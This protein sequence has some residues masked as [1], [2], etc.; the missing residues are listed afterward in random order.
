MTLSGT[1]D[2]PPASG[3]KR[4]QPAAFFSW[5]VFSIAVVVAVGLVSSPFWYG[6]AAGARPARPLPVLS[7]AAGDTCVLPL[8]RIRVEHP[9]LL[10][11]WR[12]EAVREGRRMRGVAGPGP[13]EKSLTGTCLRCHDDRAAFCDAC[14]VD[15]AVAP[16]CWQCHV[17]PAGSGGR[18]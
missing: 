10:A 5:P 4:R 8:A 3:R 16:I 12:T 13:A 9:A 7:E 14:H 6:A 18:R 17:D 11:T 1:R 2:R 15:L